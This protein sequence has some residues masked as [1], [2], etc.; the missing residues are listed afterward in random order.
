MSIAIAGAVLLA[1]FLHA[2]WNALLKDGGDRLWA[3]TVMCLAI[4][5]GAVCLGS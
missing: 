2:G 4:T 5:A 3:M 1:A